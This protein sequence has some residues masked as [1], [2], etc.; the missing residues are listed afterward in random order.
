MDFLCTIKYWQKNNMARCNYESL[1]TC[2]KSVCTLVL[3]SCV[4]RNQALTAQF[5]LW[6][7]SWERL[8]SHRVL[9]FLTIMV[10]AADPFTWCPWNSTGY[11]Q[12]INSENCSS[13]SNEAY[14]IQISRKGLSCATVKF[15]LYAPF[16]FPIRN[17]T[18]GLVNPVLSMCSITKS[19]A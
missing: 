4:V 8:H 6:T 14:L 13:L 3:G 17:W 7:L 16:F 1:F 18:Q 11:G 5:S 12:I 2:K 19:L 15:L 10:P 9:I